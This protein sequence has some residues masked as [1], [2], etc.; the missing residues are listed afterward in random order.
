VGFQGAS[1]KLEI[2]FQKLPKTI[3]YVSGPKRNWVSRQL[4]NLAISNPL[5]LLWKGLVRLRTSSSFAIFL[6]PNPGV[7]AA[8]QKIPPQ[9]T[10]RDSPRTKS[11]TA[12]QN[13]RNPSQNFPRKKI[14]PE[15]FHLEKLN[16]VD[17][18]K[19]LHR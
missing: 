3:C 17:V 4:Q 2:D 18:D 7:G 6:A 5:L 9:K 11:S 10:A 14:K 16:M 13:R 12:I 19:R 1:S 15:I 8:T